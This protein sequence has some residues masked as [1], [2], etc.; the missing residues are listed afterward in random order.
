MIQAAEPYLHSFQEFKSSVGLQ[1]KVCCQEVSQMRC[2]LTKPQLEV[3]LSCWWSTGNADH[4]GTEDL[5][6]ADYW[7][8]LGRYLSTSFFR[9]VQL[10]S[11]L[12]WRLEGLLVIS[13][14]C[15]LC[16]RSLGWLCSIFLGPKG[17]VPLS[18]APT[19]SL[20]LV[21]GPSSPP[22]SSI[23]RIL[24]SSGYGKFFFYL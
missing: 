23:L 20:S 16:K 21:T 6:D 22:I 2:N 1:K 17:L 11:W 5:A 13:H 4:S 7:H 24:F 19:I 10:W 14:D 18:Q 3:C 12:R 15:G 9:V 8:L